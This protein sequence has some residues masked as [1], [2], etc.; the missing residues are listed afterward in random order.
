MG[1][2]L[3]VGWVILTLHL[4]TAPATAPPKTLRLAIVIGHNGSPD[5]RVP[6]LRFADDDAIAT[7]EL[8]L[9]AGVTAALFVDMDADTRRL[10]RD[11]VPTGP[12]D[13][14]RILAH[15]E[16]FVHM[17]SDGVHAGRVVEFSLFYSGHGDVEHGEGFV[18]LRRGKLTRRVLYDGLLARST[19]TRNH[20]FVDACKSYYLAFERGPGGKRTPYGDSLPPIGASVMANTGFVLSTSSARDS[21]EWEGFQAGVFSHELRSALRGGA[22]V[23]G[24]GRVTYNELGAFLTATNAAILNERFR[25]DALIR[26]PGDDLAGWNQSV[27]AWPE[28]GPT[29]LLDGKAEH[30]YGETSLG[31]RLFDVHARHGETRRLHLPA[32]VRVFIHNVGNTWERLLT[33]TRT[34]D[35]GGGAAGVPVRFSDLAATR[36]PLAPRGAASL[37]LAELFAQ[38]FGIPEVTAY[39]QERQPRLELGVAA[40]RGAPVAPWLAAG[41]AVVGL[42]LDTWAWERYQAAAGASQARRVGLDGQVQRLH[43]AALGFYGVSALAAGYWLYQEVGSEAPARP[44]VRLGAGIT[45]EGRRLWVHLESAW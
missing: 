14:D 18:A 10:H 2:S 5:S 44:D 29:L 6:D 34:D 16:S 31:Q 42:S 36:S 27:I 8:L 28:D 23:D 17:M 33:P 20:V 43:A 41:L 1:T 22:D 30:I 21:H 15:F 32:G 24:D 45:P 39:A 7:Y 19:A 40:A 3:T 35:D 13:L 12:P 25:P 4:T 11:L 9:D 37:A 26:P 38:P